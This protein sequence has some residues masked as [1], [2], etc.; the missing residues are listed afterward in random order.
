LWPSVARGPAAACST[1]Q[2][3]SPLSLLPRLGLTG[4]P[5]SP[6][7]PPR[8][9]HLARLC[10]PTAWQLQPNFLARHALVVPSCRCSKRALAASASA[11]L[12]PQATPT[13]PKSKNRPLPPTSLSS[14]QS[15]VRSCSETLL[16]HLGSDQWRVMISGPNKNHDSWETLP[17]SQALPSARSTWQS[18]KNTRQTLC[19]VS[20]SAKTARHTVHRQSRLC[21]VLFLGHSAKWFAEC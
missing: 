14:S 8:V 3:R 16:G 2:P 6:A 9:A 18:F 21:R 1:A 17:E 15:R 19:R 10:G 5:R 20:Y 12:P 4:L 7:A 13:T 11:Q